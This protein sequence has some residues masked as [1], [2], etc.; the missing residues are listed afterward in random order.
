LARQIEYNGSEETNGPGW[1]SHLRDFFFFRIRVKPSWKARVYGTYQ[2]NL[3]YV[4]FF[5]ALIGC[6]VF[7]TVHLAAL[8]L[9]EPCCREEV[10][11]L[12]QVLTYERTFQAKEFPQEI[13]TLAKRINALDELSRKYLK[14]LGIRQEDELPQTVGVGSNGV[15][16]TPLEKLSAEVGY[17]S[18]NRFQTLKRHIEE[19][20]S[21]IRYTPSILPI[22]GESTGT[23]SFGNR[24]SPYTGMWELH[25]GQDL[26]CPLRTKI[27]APA[28]GTVEM[29]EDNPH[30][31]HYGRHFVINHNGM[32]KTVYGHCQKILVAEGDTVVRGQ[33]IAEVGSTGRSTGPHLHYEVIK[34]GERVDP[35]FYILNADLTKLEELLLD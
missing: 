32:Y 28:D 5:T 29:V 21:E 35:R 4:F 26:A 6:A 13:D 19:K 31:S 11:N 33:V 22:L 20:A 34:D 7:Q 27:I 3:F 2:C 18:I 24:R 25:K 10:E 23:S 12:D 14:I 16:K 9:S 8:S 30:R 15:Y 17:L 1:F